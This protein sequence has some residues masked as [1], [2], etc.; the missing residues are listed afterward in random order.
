MNQKFFLQSAPQGFNGVK[1][2]C[3]LLPALLLLTLPA[4]AQGTLNI[5]GTVYD[6]N[7]EPAVGVSVVVKGTTTGVTTGVDGS[8]NLQAAADATL[9]FSLG[10]MQ[11]MEEAVGGRARIDV[12][13]KADAQQLDEVVVVGY[14]QMRRSDLTGSVTSVSADAINKSVTTSLDQALQG[15]AAGVQ[16]TQNSGMPGG[17]SSIRIRG[18]NSLNASNEPIFVIDGVVI[19]GSTNSS[20]SNALSSINP[21]DIVTMDVLKDASATAIYGS[22]GA[23]G[24]III[25]TKRGTKGGAS[26]TYD[27]YMGVQMMPK[28]LDLLNLQEYAYHKNERTEIMGHP[29][30]DSFIRPDLLGEGTDWQDE[31]FGT[32]AMQSHNISVAGGGE[33]A[34]YS[35]GL[36]YLD[37]EGIA[38]GSGFERLNLRGSAD[39]EVKKW[40]KV[41]F[42]F[43][44]SHSKQNITV[45]DQE[46]IRVALQQ[47]P[48]V[49]ARDADGGFGGPETDEFVQSNPVGL[50]LLRENNN[51][52]SGLRS[53][54]YAD[55][56]IIDGLTVRSEFSSDIGMNNTYAFTPSYTFG[57]IKNELREGTRTKSYNIF[58]S[59]RNVATYN[60]TLGEKHNINAMLGQ[61]MQRSSYEYLYGYRSG[62]LTNGATD[63]DAGD[64]ATGKANNNS[65]ASALLSYFGR[66]FYSYDDRYLLTATLRRD[67]SSK[68]LKDNRWGW[69]P[70]AALAWK[71]S[72]EGFFKN[73]GAL[74]RNVNN[75]KVRAGWGQV[76]NQNIPNNSYLSKLQSSPTIWGT[77]LVSQNTA[78]PDLQWEKTTSFNLGL[79]VGLLRN[80]VELIVDIYNK[81]TDNLLLQV[82]MPYFLGS[83]G[84][85]EYGEPAVPGS[86]SWPWVNVGSL[87]NRG[88]ELTLNTVN[89]EMGGFTWRSNIVYSMN[90]SKVLSLDVYTTPIDKRLRDGSENDIIT[91][92]VVGQA[93]GQFYGYEVIGR[94][95]KPTDFFYYD[96]QGRVTQVALPTGQSI[97]DNGVW[98][99]D[100]MYRDVNNDGVINDADRTFIGNPEPKFSYGIGNTFTYK[101][102]DLTIYLQ[103][104]YGNKVFNWIRRRTE[105]PR[106]NYNLT[107]HATEFARLGLID[108]NGP[109]ND[110]R[111]LMV[112]S[113][114]N[115]M[116]RLAP[117]DANANTRISNRYVEDGSFLRIQNISLSYTFP[118]AWM[119]KVGVAGLKVYANIQNLYT[120]TKYK[121]YDP[122]LGSINQDALL[123][124]ID[125]ARYPTPRMFTL[126]VNVTL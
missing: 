17:S 54:V 25:T 108:P 22:R 61:E 101:G 93:I 87:Q 100:L 35:L 98:I 7:S 111:N 63:L 44:L 104:V 119:H 21:S 67:G 37:Q 107:K 32:A 47:T 99:G 39:A 56:Q 29:K 28:K 9:V 60:K 81:E 125:N 96:E 19:D 80:R 85:N 113:G 41:G 4:W 57:A 88:V 49:A 91:R 45:S 102:F 75:L 1:K 95:N 109:A 126:G 86:S 66:A 69:F 114:A 33:Q 16:V 116:S 92:T 65:G 62:Y 97:S 90:R 40:L 79:D 121:G 73:V 77:G 105:D 123:S 12:R 48:N 18:I 110:Y 89:L 117:S 13:L 11:S 51:K 26:V 83:T 24:V 30:D 70:S 14:G 76:G 118:Q 6:E 58:Y 42:N 46:L 5:S 55:F 23:N 71:I 122:E 82:P 74:N 36:G 115:D 72:N 103:G 38:L 112:V 43:A 20:N 53:N 8:Y 27:G 50:A 3:L 15:R 120:F 94:F 84:E 68:F 78:N 10:A 64:A 34:T 31:L 2:M 59:W 106:Q 52:N 124:G